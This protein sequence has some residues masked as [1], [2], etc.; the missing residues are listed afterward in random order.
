MIGRRVIRVLLLTA[1]LILAVVMVY[2][3]LFC[4]PLEKC[5][6]C[7]DPG[8]RHGRAATCD[9]CEDNGRVSLMFSWEMKPQGL[10]RNP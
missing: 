1:G 8:N 3:L 5:P 4:V 9:V 2:L 6:F 7:R 10:Y